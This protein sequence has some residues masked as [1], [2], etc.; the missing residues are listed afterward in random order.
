MAAVTDHPETPHEMH[1]AGGE[2][3]GVFLEHAGIVLVTIGPDAGLLVSIH[4]GDAG[5]FAPEERL[6]NPSGNA[7]GAQGFFGECCREQDRMAGI[8]F[9]QDGQDGFIGEHHL[10]DRFD[11]P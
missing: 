10:P 2:Q 1:L 8:E 9:P 3:V 5:T 7:L 6:F 4:Q 11:E